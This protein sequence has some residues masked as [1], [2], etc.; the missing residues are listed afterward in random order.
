MKTTHYAPAIVAL[1]T[2]KA[3]GA[4]EALHIT[5]SGEILEGTTSNFFA[6]QGDRLITPAGDE[7]LIGITREV[8]KR[9]AGPHFEVVEA[10]VKMGCFD[11]AFLTAS[12]K[13]VMPLVAIDSVPV[14]PGNVGPKTR[15]LMNLF[16]Q[17]TES[18]DW[19]PLTIARYGAKLNAQ[20]Q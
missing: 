6:F 3:L 15:F 10:P 8:I 19:P 11:E 5:P 17:Y 7:I 2:G 12:N 13:E 16:R 20:A 1:K 9:L 14:G 18:S 4:V